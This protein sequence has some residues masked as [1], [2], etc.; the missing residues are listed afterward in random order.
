M[1]KSL[2]YANNSGGAA[3]I[4]CLT[5][6]TI[7]KLFEDELSG[8]NGLSRNM[9]AGA[10]SGA[11]YKSTL[12]IRPAMLGSVVGVGIIGTLGLVTSKLRQ[13]NIIDIEMSFDD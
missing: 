4:Y 13:N 7:Q 5:G 10:I 12:G 6:W 8:F 1:Q 9:L 2:Q 3:L 11:L